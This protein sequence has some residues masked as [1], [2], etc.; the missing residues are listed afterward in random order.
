M[1]GFDVSQAVL[2][3]VRVKLYPNH[4]TEEGKYVARTDAYRSLGIHDICGNLR[5]RGSFSGNPDDAVNNITQFC[6][7]CGFLICDGFSLNLGHYSISPHVGGTW[8]SPDEAHDRVKHPV[9]FTFRTLKPLKE[10]ASRIELVV[11]EIVTTPAF[12]TDV[13]DVKTGEVNAALTPDGMVVIEG[14]R[15]KLEGPAACILIIGTR[16]SGQAVTVSIEA[17]YAENSASKIIAKIPAALQAG[18]Y[19]LMITTQYAGGS[20]LLKE[21]RRIV[22][23]DCFVVS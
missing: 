5:E 11:E 23:P 12:I 4:L 6:E 7:E 21:P 19:H 8:D 9:G 10:L 3:P 22:T 13:T 18:T 16:T 17:K 1:A 20:D 14:T 15:I 2:H